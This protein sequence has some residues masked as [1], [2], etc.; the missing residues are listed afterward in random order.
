MGVAAGMWFVPKY[1]SSADIGAV[2]PFTS[3]ATLLTIPLFALGMTAMREAVPLYD[4]RDFGRLKS[5]FYVVFPFSVFISVLSFIV[6]LVLHSFCMFKMGVGSTSVKYMALIAA[7]L[8]CA[9]PVFTDAIQAMKRFSALGI[10]EIVS[11]IAKFAAFL[12][13]M[14]L[15]SLA[16]YFAA[17]AIQPLGRILISSLLL[18]DVFFARVENFWSNTVIKRFLLYYFLILLYQALPMLLAFAEQSVIR[19]CL[20]ENDS[21]GYYFATRFSDFLYFLTLPFLLVSFPYTALAGNAR[22]RN[23]YVVCCSVIIFGIALL[24]SIVYYFYGAEL[25]SILPGGVKYQGYAFM[26]P[27]LVVITAM[28]SVQVFYTN[29]EVS[30]GSFSFLKWFIPLYTINTLLLGFASWYGMVENCNDVLLWLYVSSILR[31]VIVVLCIALS[32]RF[33]KLSWHAKCFLKNR[34]RKR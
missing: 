26:M 20:G 10:I 18:K 29:S 24:A 22:K 14:P 28:S 33:E 21:A 27:H 2:L 8:G 17:Q 13:F 15:F 1:V 11:A 12:V 25:I 6:M 5:L 23:R 3:L 7:L 30:A 34:C 4:A 32:N 19:I 31:A 9:A 16:G